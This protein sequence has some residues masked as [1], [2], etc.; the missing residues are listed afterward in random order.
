MEY[1]SPIKAVVH[2]PVKFVIERDQ[3]ILLDADGQERSAR[4]EKRERVLLDSQ[5]RP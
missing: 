5:D 4:I 2:R 1:E 3:F